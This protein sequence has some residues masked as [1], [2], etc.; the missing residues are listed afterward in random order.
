VDGRP[1]ARYSTRPPA[2]GI[3][4]EVVRQR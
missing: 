3:N 2:A 4:Y 1:V